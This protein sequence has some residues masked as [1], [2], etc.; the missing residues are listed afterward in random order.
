M[1]NRIFIKW[2]KIN[3]LFFTAAFIVSLILA[4]VIPDIMLQFVR[5]WGA[6]TIAVGPMVLEPTTKEAFFIN[7]L[8][9][10]GLMTILTL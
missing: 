5:R 10:N 7:I 1:D 4:L 8:T 3:I 6:Y 9:S 2:L